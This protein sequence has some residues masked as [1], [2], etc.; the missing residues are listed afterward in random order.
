MLHFGSH[1][2]F[3]VNLFYQPFGSMDMGAQHIA[4]EPSIIHLLS[5]LVWYQQ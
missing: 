1:S 2:I 4:E 3:L 5:F